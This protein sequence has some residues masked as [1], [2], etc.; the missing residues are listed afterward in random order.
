MYSG[1]E[2][3]QSGL[4]WAGL[5]LEQVWVVC[6]DLCTIMKACIS[7]EK[8]LFHQ[9]VGLGQTH[10]QRKPRGAFSQILGGRQG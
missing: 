9:P 6:P 3:Q 2:Y 8:F 7:A 1:D 10:L 4:P 5:Y